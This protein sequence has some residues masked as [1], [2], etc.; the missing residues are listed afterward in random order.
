M[1]DSPSLSHTPPFNSS[2]I[3]GIYQQ[4]ANFAL[5][6][7]FSLIPFL[8]TFFFFSGCENEG[9]ETLQC[10]RSAPSEVLIRA[11]QLITAAWPLTLYLFAPIIDGSF[12]KERPVEALK[13]G[14]FAR[15]PVLTG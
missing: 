8:Y 3:E 15:V 7:N 2:Y 11:G 9:V 14:R 6:F 1:A 12:L 10:L 13:A 5:V 4:F